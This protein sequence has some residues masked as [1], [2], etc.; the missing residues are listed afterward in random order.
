[1]R[2]SAD[3]TKI[4]FWQRPAGALLAS[5]V[6]CVAALAEA[7]AAAAPAAAGDAA[8]V[9]V[10][11]AN[12]D[13]SI[14]PGDNF[15]G[16]VN[17]TWLKNTEIPADRSRWGVFNELTEL[18]RQRTADLIKELAAKPAAPGSESRKIADYYASFMDEEAIEKLGFAP[19]HPA[20]TRIKA[21]SDRGQLSH[22]LGSTLRADADVLN[23]TQIETDNILGLWVAQDLDDPARYAPFL[24]QG[25]LSMPDRDYYLD[26]SPSMAEARR[27]F[28]AHIEAVLKLAGIPDPHGAAGRVYALEMRIAA[29]HATRTETVDVARGNNHWHRAD[30]D[31]RAPGMDWGKFF[32]AAGLGAQQEFV[33]WHPGAVTGIAALVGN[34]PLEDWRS[35]LSFHAIEHLGRVL[36]RA[37]V[38][39]DFRFYGT[40]LQGTPQLS[41]RWKRGVSAVNAALGDAIGKLYVARYFPPE[42]K[43][44]ITAMVQALIKAFSRR[45]EHLEW[46]APATRAQAQAKLAA[47][48]VGVGYPD[49]WIDYSALRVVRGDAYGNAER[50][51]LFDL[52][53][54]LAKLGKPVDRSEW[55]MTPQ[56]V[57]AVNLPAMNAMN[58]PAGILQPPLFNPRQAAALNFGSIGAV[59]GHEISHS[60]DDQGALFDAQGRFRN[61]WTDA[62]MAHFREAGKRLAAQYDAY[63]PF[64]DLAIN[65]QLTLSENIADVAGLAVSYDAYHLSLNGVEAPTDHGFSGDQQFFIGF[66]ST[67]RSKMREP[68]LR[69]QIVTDGHTPEEF[70]AATVRNIDAWYPAFDVQPGQKLYLAPADRV[71][72][73]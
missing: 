58:F 25:G 31:Q 64:P 18:N 19:V 42:A 54:N 8:P 5:V 21:I 27:A 60:F 23:A 44:Q 40:A 53:R 26:N 50:S 3:G 63:R 36:P 28:Q 48:K 24:L 30:F 45:I 47:L 51:E 14:R 57:N 56:T 15:F 10:N 66:A 11:L 35:Y 39:Q 62:D 9:G 7:R 22:W 4:S 37:M 69:Q 70:R 17:G 65:G 68:A 33:V 43:A 34:A 38:E 6:C 72:V 52:A 20:L 55:V 59:I 12:M 16:F 13:T 46:M 61:W 29:V 1:M 73:W 71:P 49:H 41:A 32:A 2:A 67:W